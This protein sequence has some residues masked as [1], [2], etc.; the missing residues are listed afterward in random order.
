MALRVR[1]SG[2]IVCAAKSK[3]K[4]DDIYIDDNIHA[5]LSG[6]YERMEKVIES[7]GENE[8][9]EEEWAFIFGKELSNVRTIKNLRKMQ[10]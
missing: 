8:N 5:W 10:S 6:C 3:P 4:K 7:L 9:G 2:R 1:K